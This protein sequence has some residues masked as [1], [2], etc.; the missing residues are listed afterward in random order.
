MSGLMRAEANMELERFLVRLCQE[1]S[2]S[3][4]GMRGAGEWGVWPVEAWLVIWLLCGGLNGG[5]ES[6]SKGQPC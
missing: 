2:M 4:M 5:L 1:P 6:L 3:S